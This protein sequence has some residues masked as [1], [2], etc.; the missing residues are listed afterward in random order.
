M[1]GSI[2]KEEIFLWI[3]NKY[4]RGV[5]KNF[6]CYKFEVIILLGAPVFAFQ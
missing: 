5:Y 4:V 2:L 6:L 3:F 1:P